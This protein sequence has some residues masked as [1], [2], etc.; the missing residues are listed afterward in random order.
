ME[1]KSDLTVGDILA[2]Q[3]RRSSALALLLHQ[4][5]ERNGH[6]LALSAPM[7]KTMRYETITSYVTTV[8]LSWIADNVRF[9]QDLP[10][11]KNKLDPKTNKF[12]VDTESINNIQQKPPDWR[13]QLP[14]TLYLAGPRNH[15]FSPILVVGYQRWVCEREDPAWAVDDRATRD[16]LSV[17]PLEHK[18]LYC[19]FDSDQTQFYALDGQHRLMAILGLKTFLTEGQLPFK[20]V[21]GGIRSKPAITRN[22]LLDEVKR[23]IQQDPGALDHYLQD[24]MSERIGIEIIP[25]VAKGE[26]YSESR[27]RVRRIFV[28]INAN[29]KAL[30]KD[31]LIQLN[32]DDGFRIVARMLGQ[33]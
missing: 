9:P 10:L 13:R 1:D 19:D 8:S 14:M 16:S 6:F 3:Q 5:R 2:Q 30:T 18:G 25:A 28:D 33:I 12:I 4:Q 11:F 24:L 32:E 15:K 23:R 26:T 20:D 17:A 29:A 22:M 7:G 21:N 31:E 27:F